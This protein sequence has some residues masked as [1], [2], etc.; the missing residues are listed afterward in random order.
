SM[1]TPS[2]RRRNQLR[3]SQIRRNRSL[4]DSRG[5]PIIWPVIKQALLDILIILVLTAVGIV[6]SIKARRLAG[7]SNQAI[8]ASP[9]RYGG[10]GV[11]QAALILSWVAIAC[12]TLVL[13][14]RISSGM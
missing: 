1:R 10:R 11:N 4:Q 3:H 14:V 7:Q 8:S 13:L 12:A 2:I 5:G 6:L 9:G